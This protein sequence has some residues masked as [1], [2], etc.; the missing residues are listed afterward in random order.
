MLGHQQE[1]GVICLPKKT[2]RR[3]RKA[4]IMVVEVSKV[5]KGGGNWVNTR[6]G[7]ARRTEALR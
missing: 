6:P 4:L 7:P 5:V 3:T 1:E 2:A